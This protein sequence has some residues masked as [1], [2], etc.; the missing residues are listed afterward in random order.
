MFEEEEI[1]SRFNLPPEQ[2]RELRITLD[3]PAIVE[4]R[5]GDTPSNGVA[6]TLIDLSVGGGKILISHDLPNLKDHGDITIRF[7]LMESFVLRAIVVWK[8]SNDR[9]GKYGLKWMDMNEAI[10]D[11]LFREIKQIYFSRHQPAQQLVR[12]IV[13]FKGR[14]K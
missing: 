6:C 1:L 8:D 4:I 14:W 13:R 3:K 10:K 11:E 5:K 7:E 9:Q 12:N 2:R